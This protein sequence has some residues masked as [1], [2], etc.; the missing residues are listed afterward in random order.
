[1]ATFIKLTDIKDPKEKEVEFSNPSNKYVTQ[2]KNFLNA[3]G[4]SYAYWIN[5]KMLEIYKHS[6]DISK[7]ITSFQ[8]IIS[9][10]NDKMLHYWHEVDYSRILL[11]AGSFDGVDLNET[12]WIPYNKGGDFRKWYGVQDYVIYWKYGPDDKTRGRKTFSDFYLQEYVA[13]SYTVSSSIA[14]RY[15]QPGFLWD[16]R[17]SG[18]FGDSENIKYFLGMISSKIGFEFF[19]ID[20]SVMSCQVEN[21]LHMPVIYKDKKHVIDYVNENIEIA[22]NEW[23]SFETSWKFKRHSLLEME[24]NMSR[25]IEDKFNEYKKKCDERFEKLKEN[26]VELNKMFISIY[27]LQGEVD[28]NVKDE[29]VTIRKANLEREIKSLLS[30]A[31]GCIMGRYSLKEEGLIYAG[32]DWD[33]SHYSKDFKP[34]EYGVMPI[35][36][37]DYFFEEDLCTRVIDFVKVVYGEDT[38]A[39]NLRFIAEALKPGSYDAPKKVIREYLFN[40]FF[41]DHYQIYQHR[42]IYWQM[43]S[44]KAGGFRAIVYMHRYNANTLPI[45]RTEFIQD[46]RYKYEDEMTRQKRKSEDAATTAA[47]NAIKKDITALD[48]KIVECI[49]Y[50]ELLNHAAGSIQKY[51]FD[52]DDGVKVNYAKFLSID[53]D[54]SKN[55]LTVIKL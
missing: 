39:E 51:T 23:D 4:K 20:S 40:D 45:V 35:A 2:E 34:C 36:S 17:G 55:I 30:Y 38:L 29:D 6:E 24:S 50:D 14:M 18:I 10:N 37:E 15:Y 26:E 52:L 46:L 49:A 53:G 48:K 1:M 21:I 33:D 41:N 44:G 8:G 43:D 27:G 47:K 32:G 11:D 25:K 28:P 54:K 19:K 12:Y 42:P 3:P 9:G 31:V 5:P 7:Y 16:V 13:W 22:K